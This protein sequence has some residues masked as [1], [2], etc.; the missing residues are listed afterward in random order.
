MAAF[1]GPYPPW[2]ATAGNLVV[3]SVTNYYDGRVVVVYRPAHDTTVYSSNFQPVTAPTW[4]RPDLYKPL[5]LPKK[6]R[7]FFPA[8]SRAPLPEHAPVLAEPQRP[9]PR[10]MHFANPRV[11]V[12]RNRPA[13][14]E[15]T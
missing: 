10:L 11:W 7:P 3:E 13:K 9:R 12:R 15:T 14:K 6:K 8:S 5:S 2:T 1:P 4:L